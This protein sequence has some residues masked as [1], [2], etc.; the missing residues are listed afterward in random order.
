[1][2]SGPT[3][4]SALWFGAAA[5]LHLPG[6]MHLAHADVR[7][8]ERP[9]TLVVANAAGGATDNLA[10]A[11]AEEMS[12]RLGQPIVVENIG[13]ASG[14]LGVQRVLRAP[15]DGYTLLFGTTSDMVVTP[16]ANRSAGYTPK[17]FTPIT[18]V[19]VTQMLLLAKP[20]LGVTTVDQLVALARQKPNGLSLGTAG[21]VSL[22]AFAS[23][24]LQRAA[25]IDV[26]GVPYKGGA[27]MMNDL[28]AG[29]LD[30]GVTTVP[31]ALGQVRAG[32]LVPLGVLSSQRAA[33]A[34]DIP[35]VNE[36]QGV[37]GIQIEIWAALAGPPRM[38]AAVVETLSKAA[39]ALLTDK[40]FIERRAK[41]GDVT[42]PFE[43]P[44]EF[45]RYL[46]SEEAR[47]RTLA[48]GLKLE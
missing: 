21:N 42:P 32:K 46:A 22:Q 12:A 39:H 41:N 17:D 1:M 4:R 44:A 30:L 47:Y 36:S 10:R 48:T 13:G 7:F 28:L 26:L 31:T 29:Q 34:P 5:L 23:V 43:T 11:F 8:P 15:A 6:T 9:I 38:P 33:V 18:K 27:P 35:T 14:A 2:P 3:R 45:G 20:A 16:I 40:A 37:K 24:A 19:G 25:G